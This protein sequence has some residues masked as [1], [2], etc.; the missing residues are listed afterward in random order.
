MGNRL[1]KSKS[2]RRVNNKQNKS[3]KTISKKCAHSFGGHG[4]YIKLSGDHK[5]TMKIVKKSRKA[6]LNGINHSV[7]SK[8]SHPSN[9]GFIKYKLKINAINGVIGIGLITCDKIKKDCFSELV[10]DQ[11]TFYSYWSNGEK[12][13]IIHVVHI[14]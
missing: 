2:S 14:N 4:S 7:Y 13:Q 12:E 1:S 6:K 10:I 8:Q 9:S 5:Q 3:N 11:G